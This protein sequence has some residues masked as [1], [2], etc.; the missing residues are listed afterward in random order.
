MT[1]LVDGKWVTGPGHNLG[2]KGRE[3]RREVIR[4]IVTIDGSSGF[5]AE[6][7]R[8][9]LVLCP[10][11]PHSHT[12]YIAYKLKGLDLAVSTIGTHP[13][14]AENAREFGDNEK[15][16]RD[17]VSGYRFLYEMY[18]ATNSEYTGRPSVPVLWDQRIGRIVSNNTT[19]IFSMFNSVFNEYAREPSIDFRPPDLE[20]NIEHCK[21]ELFQGVIAQ[22]YRVGFAQTQ[23]EYDAN[24]PA[25]FEALDLLEERLARQRYLLGARLT[26]ADW[27]LL[28]SLLR[29]DAI[30]NT[31]F[32]C[33]RRRI[34]DYHHLFGYLREL[35]QIPGVSETFDL[36]A[37]K[38]HYY[39]T[40]RHLNP[41]R[42]IPRT[43]DHDWFAPHRRNELAAEPWQQ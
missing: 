7:G 38:K 17:A 1:R 10:G 16:T 13:V 39:L 35:Y 27:T 21:D 9:Y 29:F 5:P 12:V 11:C 14:M 19:D 28:P 8:Y 41:R 37:A 36:D 33:A 20:K 6:P 15:A 26:E 24:E 40:H 42:I 25:L 34:Q 18:Q 23:D 31:F 30:Y 4:D 22:V 2:D 3:Q 32:Q 43:P